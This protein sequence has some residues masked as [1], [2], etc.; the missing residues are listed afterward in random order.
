MPIDEEETASMKELVEQIDAHAELDETEAISI[1]HAQD[2]PGGDLLSPVA[3][4]QQTDAADQTGP[5]V[6]ST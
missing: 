5:S 1:P 6:P 4:Q 3:D 2:Q